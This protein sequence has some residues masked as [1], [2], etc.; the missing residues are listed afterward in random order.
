MQ[1]FSQ[2]AEQHLASLL[3]R[4][5]LLNRSTCQQYYHSQAYLFL[6]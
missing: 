1:N 3:V 6:C 4:Y 2:H 5:Y